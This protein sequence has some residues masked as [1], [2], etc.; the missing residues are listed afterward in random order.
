MQGCKMRALFPTKHHGGDRNTPAL[1]NG[2]DL[3]GPPKLSLP[4]R[5]SGTFSI[6]AGNSCYYISGA[7][8]V[9]WFGPCRLT[10]LL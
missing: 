10:L 1:F 4:S 2:K 7:L 8:F 6:S 9:V 3:L 5:L